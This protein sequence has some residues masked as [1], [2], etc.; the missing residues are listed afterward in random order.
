M[1]ITRQIGKSH[2]TKQSMQ[3]HKERFFFWSSSIEV[4]IILDM[5]L[6][7]YVKNMDQYNY[8]EDAQVS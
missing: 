6:Q 2:K 7:D 3:P 4:D 8:R 5:I 1:P